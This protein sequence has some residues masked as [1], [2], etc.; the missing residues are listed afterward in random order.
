MDAV[1]AFGVVAVTVM[2]VGCLLERRSHW[3]TLAFAAGSAMTSAYA[4]L[5]RVWVVG[6]IAFVWYLVVMNR[7]VTRANAEAG[8]P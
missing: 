8:A 5:V 1:T 7:W 4:F 3:F 6:L 2:L